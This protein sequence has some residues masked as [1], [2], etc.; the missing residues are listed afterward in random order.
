MNTIKPGG[1][2]RS[3]RTP[4]VRRLAAWTAASLLAG[5]GLAGVSLLAGAPAAAA[6]TGPDCP[7]AVVSGATA[8]VT[9][10][11]T[12]GSQYWT[13]PAG[14][15]QATFTVYGAA[16]GQAIGDESGAGGFGAEVSGT[17][18]VTAGTVLQ[19]NAGQA[20]QQ[21]TTAFG[22][23]GAGG[24]QSEDIGGGGGG[25]SDV[26]APD[27]NGDY[28]L[29]AALLVAGGGGG[30]GDW[31]VSFP[32][33]DN[34]PTQPPGGNG[35]NADAAGVAPAANVDS[36]GDT[37]GAAAGGAA[38]TTTAG[39]AGGAGGSLT[40]AAG[41]SCTAVNG[42]GGTA[43]TAGTGGTGGSGNKYGAGGGGGGGY[44]GGGGGGG[45]ALENAFRETG[46]GAGGGGG[47][48][49]L[50]SAG[51]LVTDEG[52]ASNGKVVI[53]YQV[54]QPPAFTADSPPLTGGVGTAYSYQFGA[55]GTPAP[56]FSLSS[57]AP[58]WLSVD[59][60]TGTVT[61]TPPAGTTSFGYSV[62]AS[63]VAGSV[64]AGPFQVTVSAKADV[65]V[66]LSCPAGL[67]VG[68][69][70][71]CTLTVANNGPALAAKVAVGALVPADLTV[72][73]CS[74]GCSQ[75][76]GALGWSL[77]SLPAGQSDALTIGITAARAGTAVLSAAEVAATPDPNLS[78]D[79]AAATVKLAR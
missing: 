60:S 39:G 12:G 65:S 78:N 28:P 36:C 72:T 24:T 5:G 9:C 59:S 57:G 32:P 42:A 63:N 74:D 8:T 67:T 21:G 55:S 10:G 54:A 14:I 26:R 7:A 20:G 44:Y 33:P 69:S 66:A 77:G 13:V 62:T 37:F 68:A 2:R 16:G 43:G 19:V 34:A 73:G 75:L 56:T 22:G 53:T 27:A 17:L 64:T 11:Y 29:S 4:A 71:T 61:G 18:P 51:T 47:A 49:Y 38:G 3:G 46:A 70:G 50:G 45:G 23:G 30:G 79:L 1:G 48:S 76:G 6:D 41:S 35:G 40:V 15:T 31:G 52:S 25:E 58:S